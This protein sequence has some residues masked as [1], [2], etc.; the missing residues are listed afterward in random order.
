MTTTPKERAALALA[1]VRDNARTVP[2]AVGIV[3]ALAAVAPGQVISD[4]RATRY[5][6]Y[7]A[8]CPGPDATALLADLPADVVPIPYGWTA[9]AEEGQQRLLQAL[10]AG[11]SHLPSIFVWEPP[12]VEGEDAVPAGYREARVPPG[13]RWSDDAAPADRLRP[14]REWALSRTPP[15]FD[16]GNP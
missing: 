7:N 15:P 6:I 16:E 10:G 11:I 1:E 5:L 8:S 14:G 2:E 13:G 3:A 4:V 9:E 12:R